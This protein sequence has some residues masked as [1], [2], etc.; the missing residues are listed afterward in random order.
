MVS[1]N[2]SYDPISLLQFHVSMLSLAEAIDLPAPV[3]A[4]EQS[5]VAL[6]EA[7]RLK[8]WIVQ[9]QK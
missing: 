2:Q 8:T 4:K 7:E 5:K 1:S 6:T 3:G 9:Q